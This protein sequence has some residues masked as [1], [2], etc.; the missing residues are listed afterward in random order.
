LLRRLF[1]ESFDELRTNGKSFEK[2]D[3]IPFIQVLEASGNFSAT[4]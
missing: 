1:S 4:R 2:M 3:K